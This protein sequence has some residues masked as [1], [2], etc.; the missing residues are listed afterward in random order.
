[1]NTTDEAI[2]TL[3]LTYLTEHPEFL[4]VIEARFAD[5]WPDMEMVDEETEARI[6]EALTNIEAGDYVRIRN[7]AELTEYI[8]QVTQE[9]MV[10]ADV[11]PHS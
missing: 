9:A 8:N 1:M 6:G 11:Q 3:I 10:T 2:Q 7:Q 5:V 4:H